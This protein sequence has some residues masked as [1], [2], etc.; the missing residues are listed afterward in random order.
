[1]ADRVSASLKVGGVLP[2]SALPEL[3]ELIQ[4]EGVGPDW[5]ES[6]QTEGDLLAHLRNGASGVTFYAFRVRNGEFEDLQDFCARHGLTYVLSFDGLGGGWAP[7]RRIRRPQDRGQGLTCTLD[8]DRGA[9]CL[10]A[11]QIPALGLT[12]VQEILA[13][14][15]RFDLSETPPF[16]IDDAPA[17]SVEA[18]P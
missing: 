12:T 5:G 2:S 6:F 9:A 3:I 13:H 17:A 11:D 14:L 18:A 15:E 10:S 7:G 1:M 16:V 8:G 4:Q